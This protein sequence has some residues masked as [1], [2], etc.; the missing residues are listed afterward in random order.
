MD[1][2]DEVGHAEHV[3]QDGSDVEVCCACLV[4]RAQRLTSTQKMSNE[5]SSNPDLIDEP[6]ITGHN[7]DFVED[8]ERSR[9]LRWKVDLKFLPLCAFVYVSRACSDL[10]ITC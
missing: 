5:K 1:R 4:T 7:T 10:R 9:R 8:K 3:E 2:K 6:T